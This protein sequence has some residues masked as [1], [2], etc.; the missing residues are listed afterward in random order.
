[1]AVIDKL[2]ENR[3]I[4]TFLGLYQGAEMDL[5]SIAVAYY[6]ILTIF[7]LL[8]LLSTILPFL[9]IETEQ[10]VQFLELYL[11]ADL[12]DQVSGLVRTVFA[13]PNQGLLLASVGTGIWTMSKSLIFLQKAINKA[14]GVQEH[15]NLIFGYLVGI[16]ASLLVIVCLTLAILTSIFGKSL[17]NLAHSHLGLPDQV[18]G[19][20]TWLLQP[21][22][23]LIFV[24]ALALLYYVLPTVRIGK[25]TYVLPGTFFT[26][27]ILFS[28]TNLFATYVDYSLKRLENLQVF[29]S[30]A[31]FVLMLWFTFLAKILIMGAVFNASY[32]K[33]QLQGRAFIPRPAT[34]K[35]FLKK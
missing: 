22:T 1:M 16:G 7:P 4:K 33:R 25:L 3:F 21:V 27:L 32:Q 24:L 23:G 15:R 31:L 5:S 20:L 30:I 35:D 29:G 8:S 12:F 19:L 11:P 17:V 28:A 2:K 10:V 34:F 6:M 26:S 18:Y 14:Y 13:N 9:A